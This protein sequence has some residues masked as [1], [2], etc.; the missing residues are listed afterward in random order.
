VKYYRSIGIKCYKIYKRKTKNFSNPA[1]KFEPLLS[2][3]TSC[4]KKEYEP[5]AT[6]IGALP[7]VNMQKVPLLARASVAIS[8]MFSSE[9]E[10]P[11]INSKNSIDK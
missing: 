3:K 1:L 8:S 5:I 6:S 10:F 11:E 9:I 2:L 4:D 7:L